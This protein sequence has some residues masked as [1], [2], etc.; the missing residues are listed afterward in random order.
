MILLDAIYINNSGGKVLLDYLITEL[1]QTDKQVFYL[2]DFRIKDEGLKIKATNNVVYLQASLMKRRTFYK[3]NKNN[4]SSILCFGNLP[5]NI[6]TTA[7]V[8]TYFHQLLFIDL[9]KEMSFIK[10]KMYYFKT[11]ILNSFKKNTDY[12]VVQTDLVKEKL[13]RKY[14]I[15]ENSILTMPF[16]P[17]FNSNIVLPKKEYQYIYVSNVTA[18]KNHERLIKAFVKFYDI[19]KKGKLILT[20]P[21]YAEEILK[22]IN[23][24]QKE[25]YPIEN[26]GFVDRES[27]Q[28]LYA[29]SEYHIF[30]SLSES[31]G[32]G[33]VEAIENGCKIIG[34]DLPYTYAVCE[35]SIIFNP[36]EEKSIIDAFLLS[37]RNNIKPST[38]KITNDVK[39]LITLL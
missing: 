17:P 10:K 2:L 27:L 6:R 25:G 28:R 15:P 26:V 1:E 12:W 33:L 39:Q 35:P 22:M 21:S 30:P 18:H 20:I 14:K 3:E 29:E 13:S 31:F 38:N 7:K 8:Y 11:A 9:P 37:F 36:Y 4:F 24:M 23:V 5:P 16:Y 32:L 19:H 34:A